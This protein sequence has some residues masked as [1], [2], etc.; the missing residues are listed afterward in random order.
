MIRLLKTFLV[1]IIFLATV[2]GVTAYAAAQKLEKRSFILSSK[3][4][5]AADTISIGTNSGGV[6]S[7]INVAIGQYVKAGTKVATVSTG[8]KSNPLESVVTTRE[9]IVKNIS[10]P[11]N[12]FTKP[13]SEL[14]EII[15]SRNI[16]VKAE[17]IL[18]PEDLL[19]LQVG[20]PVTIT[21]A[22]FQ[23]RGSVATIFPEY[24]LTGGH[25]TIYCQIEDIPEKARLVPGM[26]AKVSLFLN[27]P[28]WETFSPYLKEL[29][30]L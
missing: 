16:Y 17:M 14:V 10:V 20:M 22:N 8:D 13:Q 26:P 18:S 23:I 6:V 7:D 21:V 4:Q 2:A 9:G 5:V 30:L 27:N 12:G 25:V 28:A 29:N 19:K 11:K 24:N 3:A 15:D 1:I